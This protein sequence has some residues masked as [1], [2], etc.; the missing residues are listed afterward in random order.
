MM[1]ALPAPFGA[2]AAEAAHLQLT[3]R[4]GGFDEAQACELLK[5]FSC[6]PPAIPKILS[7]LHSS[8]R[9]DAYLQSTWVRNQEREAIASFREA[10][11]NFHIDHWVSLC[12]SKR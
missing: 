12:F 6:Y 3:V 2:D 4:S 5:Q 7:V 1:L 10:G 11:L 8:G 9:Y